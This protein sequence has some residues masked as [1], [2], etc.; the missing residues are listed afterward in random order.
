M[1]SRGDS[2]EAYVIG[3]CNRVLGEQAL[4]QHRFDWLLG[5]P[6]AGGRGPGAGRSGCRSTRTGPAT[7]WW[8]STGSFSTTSRCRTSTSRIGSP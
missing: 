2:D 6:G 5:D 1:A 8:S 4:T 3:L 7:D